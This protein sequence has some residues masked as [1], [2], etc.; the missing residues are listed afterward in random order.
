MAVFAPM[1][2]ASASTATPA[3]VNHTP[4][5]RARPLA[6][7]PAAVSAAARCVDQLGE[8]IRRYLADIGEESLDNQESAR[9][10]DILSAVINLEHAADV[11]ANSLV[12][13][14]MRSLK[15]GKKFAAEELEIIAAM[16]AELFGSLHLALTVFLQAEPR[17]ARRLVASKAQFREFEASAM[18]LS[19]RLLRAAATSQRLADS[20]AAER[21]AEEIRQRLMRFYGVREAELSNYSKADE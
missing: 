14:S 4:P 19:A 17:E 8:A 9:A 5:A 15:R 11:L 12:E 3:T 10:Q 7:T 21:I 13:F 18:A 2:S 6:A 16:H 1:P 20:E